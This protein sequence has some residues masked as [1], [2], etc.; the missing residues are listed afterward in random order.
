MFTVAG[1]RPLVVLWLSSVGCPSYSV[2]SV[3]MCPTYWRTW[4]AVNS[5]QLERRMV[6]GKPTLQIAVVVLVIV[7]CPEFQALCLFGSKEEAEVIIEW[8]MQ[9]GYRG[10]QSFTCCL[11]PS[12]YKS[13]SQNECK[14]A[15][16]ALA[17]V[18]GMFIPIIKL[19][20]PSGQDI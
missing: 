9:G 16:I 3:S 18:V 17:A 1:D 4:S 12:A 14:K 11:L 19:R 10:S 8:M 2:C 15:A 13:P 7:Q 6:F 20:N 5:F